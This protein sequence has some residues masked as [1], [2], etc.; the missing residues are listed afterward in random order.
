MKAAEA[1]WNVSSDS[2][3]INHIVIAIQEYSQFTFNVSVV[4]LI[5]ALG[6]VVPTVKSSRLQLVELDAICDRIEELDIIKN[7]NDKQILFDFLSLFQTLQRLAST[8]AARDDSLKNL[9]TMQPNHLNRI[10]THLQAVFQSLNK[11]INDQTDLNEN[12]TISHCIQLI[13]SHMETIDS[14][15]F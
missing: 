9:S 1:I 4:L 6:N 2:S 8:A 3:N 5:A 15:L 12:T 7:K 14:N 10:K 11:T 13:L